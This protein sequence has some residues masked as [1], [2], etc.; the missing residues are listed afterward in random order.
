MSTIP[1]IES[2]LE[3]HK[4]INAPRGIKESLARYGNGT[5]VPPNLSRAQRGE[6]V[7]FLTSLGMVP[8]SVIFPKAGETLGIA[9]RHCLEEAN[10]SIGI[11]P[12]EDG[13]I[14]PAPNDELGDS[15]PNGVALYVP[16]KNQS[17]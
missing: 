1:K 17:K 9:A 4:K 11:N 3:N 15:L 5:D 8:K 14:A 7:D 10:M 16:G 6:I 13:L 2:L 12:F